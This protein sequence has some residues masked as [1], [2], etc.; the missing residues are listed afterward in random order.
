MPESDRIHAARA[1]YEAFAAGDRAFF[2]RTLSAGYRFSSPDDPL[3]DREG[4]S[5][6]AGRAPGAS[7]ASTSSASPST[8]TTSS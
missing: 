2:E 7:P 3:L 8:A 6:A 4:S 1:S 5:S